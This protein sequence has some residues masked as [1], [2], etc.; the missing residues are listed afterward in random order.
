MLTRDQRLFLRARAH[1]CKPIVRVGQRG[2]T[3]AV[4]AE[5][6][7]ALRAHELVKVKL[8]AGRDQRAALVESLCAACE[9]E[10]VQQIG[11]TVTLFRR[12]PDR[13]RIE[14]PG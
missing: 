13:P 2:L 14:L 4:T 7:A 1:G 9:A 6:D 12:N 3:D 10:A 8:A 11:A 5:L